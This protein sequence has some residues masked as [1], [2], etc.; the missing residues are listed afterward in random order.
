MILIILILAAAMALVIGA[1]S[2]GNCIATAISSKIMPKNKALAITALFMML[3]L[4][5]EGSKMEGSVS[6]GIIAGAV[7]PE[8][9]IV[10]A[11]S[12]ALV[13]TALATYFGMPISTS[14]CIATSFA[15][16]AFF[17]GAALNLLY[18]KSMILAWIL[19]PL[20]AAILSIAFYAVYFVVAKK[21]DSIHLSGTFP[22]I[23]LTITS[24]FAAYS[25]G[26]NTGGFL[27]SIAQSSGISNM[28]V[29]LVSIIPIGLAVYFLSWKV[30]QTIGM[31]ITELGIITATV[32]QLAAA[33]VM[34][35]FTQY[36]IPTSLSLAIVGGV[37][38]IGIGFGSG[39]KTVRAFGKVAF[40]WVVTPIISAIISVA[41]IYLV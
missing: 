26:A 32:S 7:A 21:V 17:V 14:Q 28:S 2:S 16:S 19:T 22:I 29:L 15:V 39:W 10:A 5:L 27:V 1:N 8:I 36:S 18:I 40:W 13:A 4:Y 9:I 31:G 12:G 35:S 25:L 23:L 37:A 24:I 41:I 6:G 11:L 33:I 34:Y 3:G 38:G 20:M 30:I